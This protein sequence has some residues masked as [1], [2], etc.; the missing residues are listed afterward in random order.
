M[1]WVA[2]GVNPK[3]VWNEMER[4]ERLF[5]IAEKLPKGLDD[6]TP[7]RAARSSRSKAAAMARTQRAQVGTDGRRARRPRLHG[8][9]DPRA[10]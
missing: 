3:D 6:A 2:S 7:I 9:S 1:L 4:R 8:Q 5:G 10:G